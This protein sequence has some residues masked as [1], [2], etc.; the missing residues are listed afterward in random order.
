[1]LVGTQ[2]VLDLNTCSVAPDFS[3]LLFVPFQVYHFSRIQQF[4]RVAENDFYWM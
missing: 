4:V 2:C 3:K 1:M